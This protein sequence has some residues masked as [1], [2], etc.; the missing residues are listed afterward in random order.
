[1]NFGSSS[2]QFALIEGLNIG[3]FLLFSTTFGATSLVVDAIA[4][5][6]DLAD[7]TI[8]VPADGIPGEDV[9]ISYTVVNLNDPTALSDWYDSLYL[10]TSPTFGTDAILIGR[11]DHV[12]DVAGHTS[13][14]GTLTAPLPAGTQGSTTSSW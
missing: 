1:M 10:L 6:T 9:T 2:G 4:D 7:S 13:Y 14:S 11:V 12:G 8:T 5:S 3:R